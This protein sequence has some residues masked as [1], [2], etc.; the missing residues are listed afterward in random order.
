[1]ARPG[2]SRRAPTAGDRRTMIPCRWACSS[3]PRRS[4][5]R[6]KTLGMMRGPRC[7]ASSQPFAFDPVAD[8]ERQVAD[9]PASYTWRIA[10][11]SSWPSASAF[12]EEP[13]PGGLVGVEIDA[14]AHPALEDSRRTPRTAPARPIRRRCARAGSGSRAPSRCARRRG[15]DRAVSGGVPGAARPRRSRPQ[16]VGSHQ[17]RLP[18]A[19]CRRRR[20]CSRSC[21]AAPDP[22]QRVGERGPAAERAIV[23]SGGGDR[24][25]AKLQPPFAAHAGELLAAGA[26][27][28][29]LVDRGDGAARR[30]PV[31]VERLGER[32]ELIAEIAEMGELRR[33]RFTASGAAAWA[34][35]VKA[36][37]SGS[38]SGGGACVPG[39]D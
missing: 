11:W 28:E 38:R 25:G 12:A 30:R 8:P 36:S 32:G 21:R 2:R 35:R 39:R 15:R 34:H 31:G 22:Y 27:R 18:V 17:R 20:G 29:Q 9:W 33:A 14:K 5:A 26:M 7:T 4:R 16:T 19:M 1:M 10:G 24:V 37:A 3:A 23:S 6:A 13:G